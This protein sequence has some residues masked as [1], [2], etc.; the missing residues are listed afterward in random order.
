MPLNM[1]SLRAMARAATQTPTTH[2][3][4]TLYFCGPKHPNTERLPQHYL[5]GPSAERGAY[6]I[7]D[8]VKRY[9]APTSTSISTPTTAK[10]PETLTTKEAGIETEDSQTTPTTENVKEGRTVQ[11]QVRR[12]ET[13]LTFLSAPIAVSIDMKGERK[14]EEDIK[15]I[16]MADGDWMI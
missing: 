13:D 9:S 4:R 5:C 16:E 3:I 10:G 8:L 11:Y 2:Q 6:F 15:A 12:A 7:G 1:S 14:E